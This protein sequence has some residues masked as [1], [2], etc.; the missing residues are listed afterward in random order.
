M[1]TLS[2]ILLSLF[3]GCT[4]SSA[5]LKATEVPLEETG[6][7]DTGESMDWEGATLEVISPVSAEF[8]PWKEESRYEAVIYDVDGNPLDFDEI[9]WNSS[10]DENWAQTGSLF[11][12]DSLDVGL[13]TITATA[14]LPNGNRLVYAVGGVRVQSPYAGTFAGT[15]VIDATTEVDGSGFTVGCAGAATLV[16]DARGEAGQGEASCILSLQGQAIETFYVLDLANTEGVLAGSAAVD[17]GFWEVPMDFNGEA[18]TDGQVTGNFEA[19]V[20]G[21]MEI[22]GQLDVSRVSLDTVYP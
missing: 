12:D 13:H 4:S 21:F 2:P 9:Q 11:A 15:V 22:A 14:V 10:V 8:I 5:T 20:P 17:L 7:E 19:T 18:S 6:L 3:L 1:R 16:V